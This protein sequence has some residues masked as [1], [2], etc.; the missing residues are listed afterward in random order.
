MPSYA[1]ALLDKARVTCSPANYN[2]LA[3]RLGVS[4]QS[5][6]SWR[7]GITPLPEARVRELARMAHVDEAEWWLAVQA[8]S[9]PE[10][11]KARLRSVLARAGIAALLALASLPGMASDFAVKSGSVYYVRRWLARRCEIPTLA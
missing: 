11:M 8:D 3:L 4:R 7:N 10:A 1:A 2:A 6:S 5:V 9:A